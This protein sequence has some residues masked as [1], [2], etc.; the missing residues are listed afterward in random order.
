MQRLEIAPAFAGRELVKMLLDD[1]AQRLLAH[2]RR[3]V[4]QVG[5]EQAKARGEATS[6]QRFLAEMRHSAQY[7][8][9]TEMHVESQPEYTPRRAKFSP[10]TNRMVT[11]NRALKA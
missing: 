11:L 9:F 2:G 5:L 1:V 8:Y 4:R 10:K 6:P 7:N 3:I